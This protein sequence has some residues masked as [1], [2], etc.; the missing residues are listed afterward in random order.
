MAKRRRQATYE[1][2]RAKITDDIEH[3]MRDCNVTYLDIGREL[4]MS[5]NNA[6][7]HVKSR[8]IKLSQILRILDMF[9]M[10]LYTVM[11]P[12]KAWVRM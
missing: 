4:G 8:D 11:R 5:Q 12:H 2:V 3:L 10:D 6:R 7:I 1:R 9:G